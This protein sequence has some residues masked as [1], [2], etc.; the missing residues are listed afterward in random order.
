MSFLENHS[1]SHSLAHVVALPP[2]STLRE[3][4]KLMRFGRGVTFD[5]EKE[6]WS[7]VQPLTSDGDMQRLLDAK[8]IE[9]DSSRSLASASDF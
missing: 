2:I 1:Y 9:P 3:S 5:R 4:E 7:L 6:R 8:D